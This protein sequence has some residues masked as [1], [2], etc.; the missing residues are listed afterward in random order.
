MKAR[1]VIG[2]VL[3]VQVILV[4]WH[5]VLDF[6]RHGPDAHVDVEVAQPFHEFD[7]EIGDRHR[8]QRKTLDAA[9]IPGDAQL[10]VD[11]IEQ[12]V[13]GALAA[14]VLRRHQAA[15]VDAEG[16]VPPMIDERRAGEPHLAGD[17]R[18]QLQRVAGLAPRVERQVGPVRIPAHGHPLYSKCRNFWRPIRT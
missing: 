16:R 10:V 12:N 2:V 7:V 9:V 11:K 5:R 4:E 13:E 15:R 8:R 1:D 14:A 6:N 18:P 17:L 3:R